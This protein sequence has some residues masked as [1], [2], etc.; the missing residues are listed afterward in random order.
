[1]D[2][3]LQDVN[4]EEMGEED[5]YHKCESSYICIWRG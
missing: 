3:M 4:R 2:F 1:M 5:G